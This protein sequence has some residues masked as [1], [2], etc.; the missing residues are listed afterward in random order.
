[1]DAR[2]DILIAVRDQARLL[3]DGRKESDPA[4]WT[5]QQWW[6][7]FVYLVRSSGGAQQAADGAARSRRDRRGAASPRAAGHIQL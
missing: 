2:R 4:A 7:S 1:M 6:E 5:Q 3:R